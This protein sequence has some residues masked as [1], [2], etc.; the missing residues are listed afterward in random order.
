MDANGLYRIITND[1]CAICEE[2][3]LAEQSTSPS[4]RLLSEK[5]TSMAHRMAYVS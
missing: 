1:S 4:K 5:K 2:K 3:S